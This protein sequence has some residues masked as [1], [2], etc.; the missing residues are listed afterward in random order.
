MNKEELIKF[1]EWINHPIYKDVG[2]LCYQSRVIAMY[3]DKKEYLIIDEKGNSVLPKGK[4][5]NTEELIDYYYKHR[6]E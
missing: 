1:I 3:P 6:N 5:L 2:M 4:F